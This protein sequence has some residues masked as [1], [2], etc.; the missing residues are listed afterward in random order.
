MIRTANI[1]VSL[2]RLS[3]LRIEHPQANPLKLACTLRAGE[4]LPSGLTVTAEIHTSRNVAAET[5]PLAS[6]TVTVGAGATTFE[7]LFDSP[8]TN[9]TVTPDSVRACWLVVYG[10]ADDDTVYTLSAA[11]LL[12][13]WHAISQVTAAPPNVTLFVEKGGVAWATGRT[14]ASGTMVTAGTTAYVAT[15]GHTSAASTEPGEGASWET[16][17][18]VLSGGG[19]ASETNLDITRTAT[20]VTITNDNGDGVEIAAANETNAGV[21]PAALHTKL[22][23]LPTAAALTTS[24]NAKADLVGG[25]LSTSQ[26]PDLAIT[27]YLGAAANQAAM[28]LLVGQPGDWCARTDDGKVY[29]VTAEPSSTLGN[30]TS[31]SYPTAP[32]LSVAGRTGS[33]TIGIGDIID[34]Q[35]T[36]ETKVNSDAL[37]ALAFRDT[38]GSAQIDSGAVTEAKLA[39]GSVTAAKL[40]TGAVPAAGSGTELQFRDGGAFGALAGS[41]VSGSVLTVAEFRVNGGDTATGLRA[42]NPV[43]GAQLS[44]FGTG[45]NGF[46]Y[47]PT[48]ST[49]IACR[50]AGFRIEG[51][52]AADTAALLQIGN[53]NRVIMRAAALNN[54]ALGPA[55]AAS[56]AAQSICVQS[57]S[58]T[59]QSASSAV[60]TL[61]GAQGTGT[62][63]GGDVRVRVAPNGST[64]SSLN[65]LVEAIRFRSTDLATVCAGAI[66]AGGPMV[67]ATFTVSTVPAASL[68]SRGLIWVSDDVG[69]ATPAFSDGT[70]WRRVADRAVVS[71][72]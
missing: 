72:P 46:F 44:F 54:L 34:L 42:T 56:P 7:V 33:V 28:L 58:G 62:G 63:A 64:G 36:L 57:A 1:E 59:N 18:A 9:Q 32:V 60:F 2:Q 45:A 49:I 71:V 27:Q 35:D 3:I 12:L 22:T 10:V 67:M 69:G 5:T 38:V 25:K 61:D 31:L 55:N 14:Y 21:F 41:S 39:D 13:G 24:L 20:A 48:G 70:N 4:S 30:W 8:Q 47:G 23:D 52:G 37:F 17:W 11:D 19:G 26:L 66:T 50:G 65:T 29:I 15:A 40:A 68:W 53:T 6:S 51:T 43:G 16:V